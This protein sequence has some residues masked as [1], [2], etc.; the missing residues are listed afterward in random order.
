MG[1]IA[2]TS[3][4][5]RWNRA[6]TAAVA[7]AACAV[8]LP[9]G[10]CTYSKIA[11]ADGAATRPAAMEGEPLHVVELTVET[12]AETELSPFET[13]R[14]REATVP[15]IQRELQTAC[16]GRFSSGSGTLPVVVRLRTDLVEENVG[17]GRLLANLPAAATLYTIPGHDSRKLRMGVS[18]QLGIGKWSD[19]ETTAATESMLTF[20]PLANALF[21]GFLSR[22]NGW[23]R[24]GRSPGPDSIE[25]WGT[26]ATDAPF[27][28]VEYLQGPDGANPEFAKWL[29]VRIADAW[30]DLLPA[31]KREARNNPVARKKLEE[32]RS[33]AAPGA[34]ANRE[35]VPVPVPAPPGGEAPLAKARVLDE[36]FDRTTRRGF[37]VFAPEDEG[38][39]RAMEWIRGKVV[40]RLAGEGSK[41]RFLSESTVEEGVF[42]I[43]FE[44]VE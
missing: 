38:H 44:A 6:F 23:Q 41:V 24:K 28:V 5:R 16:A 35:V 37:V 12:R 30:D 22:E 27:S 25:T 2:S 21:S 8:L 18:I 10:G 29:A 33:H 42:R 36:G 31:E 34:A 9:C 13:G 4:S 40:P 20:N 15:G 19:A 17:I 14:R 26:Y 3:A 1:R 43:E 7:L 32:L 39:L 11:V